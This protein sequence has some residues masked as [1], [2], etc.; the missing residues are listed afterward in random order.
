MFR[1]FISSA[2]NVAK[3]FGGVGLSAVVA[4]AIPD[5]ELK[6]KPDWYQETVHRLE[7]TLKKLSTYAYIENSDILED[8]KDILMRCENVNNCEI[9]WRLGRALS[10]K[11]DL[12]SVVDSENRIEYFAKAIPHFQKAFTLEPKNGSAGAHKWYAITLKRLRLITSQHPYVKNANKEVIEHLEKAH[13]ID[14]KDAITCHLLGVEYFEN[15]R[16]DEAMKLFQA[17]EEIKK[18]FFPSNVYYIGLI[19]H[20]QNKREEAMDT[21]KKVLKM[22]AKN[23]YDRKAKANARA[24]LYLKYKQTPDSVNPFPDY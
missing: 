7:K 18:D 6:N 4:A 1:R 14:P 17:A 21:M 19:Q 5:V 23:K 8:A 15:G 22:H 2:P 9:S 10:E 16:Y 13:Q 24:L 12:F 3:V 20:K 11:G